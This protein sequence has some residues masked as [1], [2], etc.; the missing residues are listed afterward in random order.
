MILEKPDSYEKNETDFVSGLTDGFCIVVNDNIDYYDIS[1]HKIY[2]KRYSSLL[3]E[4]TIWSES[5]TVYANM[6]SI[7]SG[8][9][10]SFHSSF[11]PTGL[12]IHVAPSNREINTLL[13]D[14]III[15][16]E[17]G[18]TNTYPRSDER[19][20]KILKKYNQFHD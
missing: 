5:F 9:I 18:D 8:L 4:D 15:I 14:C 6:D 3:D 7:Y 16:D 13:L 2:F 12:V 11:L 17:Y 10:M 20:V 19:I 1:E